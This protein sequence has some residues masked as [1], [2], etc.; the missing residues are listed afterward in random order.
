MVS[1]LPTWDGSQVGSVTRQPFLQSLL[2]F[3]FFCPWIS[4]RQEQ[5]WIRKID[6]GLIT[7]SPHWGPC[8]STG[9]GLFRFPLPLLGISTK[10]IPTESWE[11]LTCQV[12]G[13]YPPPQT[14]DAGYFHS[15][16]WSTG[17]LFC[18]P[19]PTQLPFFSLP[20]PFP[21]QVPPT[22]CLSWLFG[23]PSYSRYWRIL[24][25]VPLLVSYSLWVVSWILYEFLANIHL[26]VST[27]HA[28]P[29]GSGLPCSGWYFLIPL[30]CLQ[31][32]WCPHFYY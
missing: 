17:L 12:T 25:W 29:F 11:S 3:F 28:C 26:S 27:Y 4:F 19:S 10:I 5:F 32:S 6:S 23:S 18:N 22:L 7:L 24:T 16:S 21:T 13:I 14:Q 8:L 20:L 2:H 30:I 15:F 9:L 31:N 1:S